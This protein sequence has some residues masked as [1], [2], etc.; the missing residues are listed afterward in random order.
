VSILYIELT[1]LSWAIDVAVADV[2]AARIAGPV[3]VVVRG[4]ELA[5]RFRAVNVITT[6]I[7]ACVHD[8]LRD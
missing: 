2:V 5:S 6:K 7:V 8:V 1:R 4:V 3:D